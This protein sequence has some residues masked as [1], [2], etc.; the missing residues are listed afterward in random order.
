MNEPKTVSFWLKIP[1]KYNSSKTILALANASL[2]ASLKQSFRNSQ[3]GVMDADSK[4]TVV[5]KLPSL[6][7]WHHFGY[8]FDGTHSHLYIDGIM[9]GRSSI[10]PP[11]AP[12]TSFEIGRWIDGSEYFEGSLDDLRIY[13]RALSKEELMQAMNTPVAESGA[14]DVP[15]ISPGSG[16]TTPPEDPAAQPAEM[17]VVDLKLEHR[18]YHQGDTV[19]TSA[20]WIS[21]PS[22]QSRD[23][24][25]KL[26]IELP[27]L[28]PISL[29]S[30]SI[31]EK[32]TLEPGF[33]RNYG[34]MALLEIS[35]D[36]PAGTC[37]I[38][39]RLTDPVTGD[40]LSEDIQ[41]FTIA[42]AKGMRPRARVVESPQITMTSYV[43]DSRLHYLITN[44]GK[45]SAEIEL[46]LW[47]ENPDG[48]V[49]QNFSVGSD[50][51][52][53]LAPNASIT[54]TSPAGTQVLKSKL[55]NATTGA[56]LATNSTN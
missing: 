30:L 35:D 43:E 38:G 34:A 19:Q 31:E 24:E 26:W 8:V 9:V 23:V 29:G 32:L 55:L 16:E 10:A 14:A 37:R 25:L 39:A 56:L 53:T 13:T 3:A 27:G 33:N 50:N 12:V 21:N 48:T 40:V 17:P 42:A 54:L 45:I 2:E 22:T 49:T 5:G 11:D 52:L 20:F 28:Q 18:T 51:S 44:R 1:K 4:W 41:S 47:L 7:A 36:S 46:K 6:K 15:E